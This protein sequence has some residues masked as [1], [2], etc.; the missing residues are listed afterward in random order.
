MEEQELVLFKP[1]SRRIIRPASAVSDTSAVQPRDSERTEQAEAATTAPEPLTSATPVT[2]EREQ[3]ALPFDA[4][5]PVQPVQKTA[6][7]GSSSKAGRKKQAKVAPAPAAKP[8]RSVTHAAPVATRE[9]HHE[10][11]DD[12]FYSLVMRIGTDRARALLDRIEEELLG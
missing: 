1:K 6:A 7:R 4:L 2:R 10:P 3:S 9:T 8:A 11:V 5:E 12:Q